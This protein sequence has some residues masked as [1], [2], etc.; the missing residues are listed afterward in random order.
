MQFGFPISHKMKIDYNY[1]LTD[2]IKLK[3]MNIH[4]RTN[5]DSFWYFTLSCLETQFTNT[6][7]QMK[8]TNLC[9]GG[10]FKKFLYY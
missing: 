8:Q 1:K 10:G 5:R 9:D 7:L 4:G 3:L 6:L 2:E